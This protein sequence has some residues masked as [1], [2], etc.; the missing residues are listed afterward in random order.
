VNSHPATSPNSHSIPDSEGRLEQA[1][2]H[3]NVAATQIRATAG[4]DPFAPARSMAAQLSLLCG[5][6]YAGI[7]ALPDPADSQGP[8]E[9]LNTALE[10]LDAIPRQQAPPD[11]MVWTLRLAQLRR[12]VRGTSKPAG[13][14]GTD[15][16][17]SELP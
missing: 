4:D 11:L 17:R 8:L 10:L 16:N 6:L 2:A 5:G 15:T 7:H 14:S 12:V 3:L 9:H 1:C 13:P